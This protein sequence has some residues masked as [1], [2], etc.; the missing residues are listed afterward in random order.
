[1]NLLIS[2]STLSGGTMKSTDKSYAPVL[3][4]RKAFLNRHDISSDDTTLVQVVYEGNDYRR[5]KT[6]NNNDKGD[7]ITRQATIISDGLVVTKPGH[8]LFLPLADCIG[9][10]LHDPTKDIL[11][12]SHLGRHNLEQNGGTESVNYLI[13]KHGVNPHNL[14]V[15]L[16]PAAGKDNYPLYAFD[17]RGLHEVAIEQLKAAGVLSDNI[18]ASPIDSAAD[19]NYFSHSQFL[20]GN[21]E[22]DGRFAIVATLI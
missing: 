21:R 2:T 20:K 22:T 7:G 4:A 16:S 9:A 8:A 19:P 18:T 11:M 10:V 13:N 5:Y 1:M 12:V 15:W 3:L 14:T 6:L 17:N